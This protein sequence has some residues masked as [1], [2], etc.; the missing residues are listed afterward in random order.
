MAKKKKNDNQRTDGLSRR[1]AKLQARAAERAKFERDPRPFGD[2]KDETDLIA[3]QEFVPSAFAPISVTGTDRKVLLCTVLPGGA[4]AIVR[5]DGEALVA[6]Q[7]RTPSRNPNR[8][9]AY[10]LAWVVSAH[11]GATLENGHADGTEPAL[12]EI[13][14]PTQDIV[15]DEHDNFN[16]WLPEAAQSDPQHLQAI[17]AANES[18]LPSAKVEA[19]ISGT[20][21]WINPGTKAHIRWVRPEA[22]D[23]VLYALARI[24]ARGELKL[25]AETKFAGA[26]RTHGI[27]VPVWDLDPHRESASY[28]ADLEALDA[29]IS[30]EID[31][32]APLSADERRQ[33]ENIK[34]RQVTLR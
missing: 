30:A 26:F 28:A 27:V 21:W 32:D 16:W 9:L 31:N 25:G 11:P 17:E 3:V 24:A 23:Q 19:K 34:S 10:A 4:A 15:F 6:L 33:L 7:H 12:T 18:V 5:E 14:D 13:L 8:D 22:E 20:A 2:V 1:Q 29:K